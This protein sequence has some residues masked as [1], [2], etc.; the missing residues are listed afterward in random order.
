MKISNFL[1]LSFSLFSSHTHTHSLS[2]SL[3]LL[4][5]TTLLNSGTTECAGSGC[6]DS[7]FTEG[8]ICCVKPMSCAEGRTVNGGSKSCATNSINALGTPNCAYVAC[9]NDDFNAG[10]TCC[11]KQ[12]AAY[13]FGT[14]VVPSDC[15]G[16]S[17][18]SAPCT[19]NV[20]LSSGAECSVKCDAGYVSKGD[21]VTITCPL[22]AAA[23]GAFTGAPTCVP[24]QSCSADTSG[25][26]CAAGYAMDGAS[27]C[28]SATCV[29]GDFG[30][31][32][33][34]CAARQSCSADTSGGTC[35]VSFVK[36]QSGLC[37]GAACNA[38]DFGDDTKACCKANTN[39]VDSLNDFGEPWED[40]AA[41]TCKE[42]RDNNW[43]A[44]NEV[45]HSG[46]QNYGA[47]QNCCGCGKGYTCPLV[48]Q[49][50]CTS[51]KDDT[52]CTAVT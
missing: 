14:G 4:C 32:G 44:G 15:S 50:T 7:E 47:E 49:A 45:V 22:S 5:S 19:N 46:Y 36:D 2:L 3:F 38:G 35:A 34:C 17:C 31:N 13:T 20:A 9:T 48:P 21:F 1:F 27:L 6:V 11:T 12:C 16:S 29:A 40:F 37:A 24:Q 42:Y 52:T 28:A 18:E 23:G 30:T 39:C 10:S 43:C 25:G 33:A 26:T 8:G 51:C 41:Y